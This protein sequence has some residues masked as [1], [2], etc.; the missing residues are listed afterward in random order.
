MRRP[1]KSGNER[2]PRPQLV[3]A[4]TGAGHSGGTA[5]DKPEEGVGDGRQLS[6]VKNFRNNIKHRLTGRCRYGP[7]P[8][9]NTRPTKRAT[10]GC[11]PERGS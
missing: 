8:P 10:M 9:G 3:P 4:P 11:D 2:D 5:G 1:V 6:G 7:N